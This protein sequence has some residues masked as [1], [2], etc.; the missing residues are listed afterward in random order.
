MTSRPRVTGVLV[1]IALLV[2]L[3]PATAANA[4]A[5]TANAEPAVNAEPAATTLVTDEPAA[6]PA[7][8]P[9]MSPN[10]MP[11]PTDAPTDEIVVQADA[12]AEPD[13]EGRPRS[14]T[15][16]PLPLPFT[17]PAPVGQVA[18]EEGLSMRIVSPHYDNA[19][20]A[21]TIT[22][23]LQGTP[24]AYVQY[25]LN[26]TSS[27]SD[28]FQ[29][30]E[31]GSLTFDVSVTEA[32]VNVVFARQG[33]SPITMLLADWQSMGVSAVNPLTVETPWSGAVIAG[34]T[35][36]FTGTGTGRYA[37][38]YSVDGIRRG[39]FVIPEGRYVLV[40]VTWSFTVEGVPLDGEHRFTFEYAS[41]LRD[42]SRVERSVTVTPLEVLSPASYSTVTYGSGV[43]FSGTGAPRATVQY[44]WDGSTTV[45]S[46]K[47]PTGSGT[48]VTW[49]EL[50]EVPRVVGWH[51]L[52]FSYLDSPQ[53]V[54]MR[55]WVAL[56][57]LTVSAPKQGADVV[58]GSVP[59]VVEGTPGRRVF[60][61]VDDGEAQGSFVLADGRT[62]QNVDLLVTGKH[63]VRFWYETTPDAGYA[64]RSVAVVNPIRLSVPESNMVT[65]FADEVAFAGTGAEAYVVRYAIDGTEVGSFTVGLAPAGTDWVTP[66]GWS[67]SVATAGLTGAHTFSFWYKKF[68]DHRVERTLLFGAPL[69]IT[70]PASESTVVYGAVPTF[71]GTGAAGQTVEYQVD[72]A[73][74]GSFVIPG[75]AGGEA[76]SWSREI[77]LP[78][79][80]G[81]HRVTF[82]Y[83]EL[84][85]Q[86][87]EIRLRTILVP[88][89]VISP[90]SDDVVTAGSV[91]FVLTGTAGRKVWFAVDD[92]DAQGAFAMGTGETTTSVELATP[93]HHQVTFWYDTTPDEG[94][95]SVAVWVRERAPVVITTPAEGAWIVGSSVVTFTGTA[96]PSTTLTYAAP[97]AD[98]GGDLAVDAVGS[99]TQPLRLRPGEQTVTFA[100]LIAG[101]PAS[102]LA[103]D[104]TVTVVPVGAAHLTMTVTVTRVSPGQLS[105]EVAR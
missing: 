49:W 62:T 46:F 12:A 65:A 76:A 86:R 99:W 60:Y 68:P 79:A 88:L 52:S 95:V 26:D 67:T 90:S 2:G 59:F 66:V 32:S 36:T 6:E 35:V 87:S 48:R 89:V 104:R 10:G 13:S 81:W 3:L 80:L 77:R 74:T 11:S 84:P 73:E 50:V 61:A 101:A 40:P 37:V 24:D 4:S 30:S 27:A 39:S 98:L 15:I 45:E 96:E 41:A 91:P 63:T 97:R 75:T 18:A 82:W 22:V 93:G 9:T 105:R 28:I 56:E 8:A 16:A 29:L 38:D 64:S 92:G 58:A 57:E 33:L 71:A 70:S 43:L 72:G 1:T 5:P 51:T 31:R 44:S 83:A 53:V 7:V 100:P 54:Q 25:A 55:L 85:D 20:C 17:A 34:D 102:A 78:N 21:G 103:V 19:V 47:I 94:G 23:E 42:C 69:E 14:D